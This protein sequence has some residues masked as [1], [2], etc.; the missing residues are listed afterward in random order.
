[1]E[2][3]PGEGERRAQRGYVTQYDFAASLIYEGLA[4]GKL[5]WIGVADRQAGKFDDLVLGYAN[6]IFAYQV[7]AS[8]DPSPFS[9]RTQLLGAENLLGKIVK[10]RQSISR[11]AQAASVEIIYVSDNFPRT[12]D[13]IADLKPPVSSAAYL[14]AHNAHRLSWALFD[15]KSSIYGGFVTE[16]QEAT[17]LDDLDFETLWRYLSFK[18]GV[19]SRQCGLPFPSS[20][21]QKRIKQ[22][23]ALLPRLVADQS[24]QDRWSVHEVLTKLQW[25]SPFTLRHSHSFP[26]DALYESNQETQLELSEALHGVKSGYVALVGPP[27]SGKST[28]LAAGII[29]SPRARVLRYLAFVPGKGQGLGRAESFD[30]LHDLVRQLKLQGFGKEILP[31]GEI[32]ELRAQLERLL[33]E[34]GERYQVD[35]LETIIVVDGLDHVSR[36]ER[37]QRSFLNDFPLPDSIPDGVIFLLG[38]QRLDLIDLPASVQDQASEEGRLIQ[39]SPLSPSAVARLAELAGVS[40]D[41][42]GPLLYKKTGGHPLA[43]RYVIDGLQN[44]NGPQARQK[45]LQEGPAYGG[46]VDVFYSRAWHDLE[47]NPDAQRG[48][49]YLALAEGTIS[50]VS[51]DLIIGAPATDT[52]WRAAN[53]LLRID[54]QRNWSV[55]HNSFRLFLQTKLSMRHGVPNPDVVMARYLELADIAAKAESG[56]GQQ[57]LELR[58]RVRAKQFERALP[59]ATPDRFREQ[60]FAGRSPEDIRED[61]ALS[62]LAAKA[63]KSMTAVLSLIFAGHE[64]DMR[65]EVVGDDVIDAYIALGFLDRARGLVDAEPFSMST[66]KGFDLVEILLE[67]GDI[68]NAK[69]VFNFLEPLDVL[70]GQKEIFESRTKTELEKWAEQALAFRTTDEFITSLKRMR[71]SDRGPHTEDLTAQLE[72]LKLL[73]IR[74]QLMRNPELSPHELATSLDLG[75]GHDLLINYLALKAAF[76]SGMDDLASERLEICANAAMANASGLL[77]QISHTAHQLS[78]DDIAKKLIESA[79]IPSLDLGDYH[80]EDADLRIAEKNVILASSLRARFALPAVHGKAP[81]SALLDIYQQRLENLGS[82]HGSLLAEPTTGN[83]PLTEMISLLDFLE[84]AQG[85]ERFD[86]E[87]GRLTRTMDV[88]LRPLLEAAHAHS[89][90]TFGRLASE[91]DDRLNR[92]AP[93]LSISS[94]RRAFAIEMFQYEDDAAAAIRRIAYQPGREDTPQSEFEEVAKTISAFLQVGLRSEAEKLLACVQTEGLGI[95]RPAKKDGQYILWEGFLQ[96]ANRADPVHRRDRVLFIARFFSGLAETEGRGVA[97]RAA[98]TLIREA[99]MI[100]AGTASK[101]IDIVEDFNLSTWSDIVENIALGAIRTDPTYSEMAAL[102]FGRLCIPFD[103]SVSRSTLSEILQ[104]APEPEFGRIG[105]LLAECVQTDAPLDSRI[106]ALETIVDSI[107]RRG[108]EADASGLVRWRA[109]LPPPKSGNSP[110]DPFFLARSLEDIANLLDQYRG[111]SDAYGARSAFLRVLEWVDFEAANALFIKE[112]DLNSDERVIEAMARQSWAEGKP[113]EAKL[114]L[115]SLLKIADEKGSWGGGWRSQAKLQYHRLA[116]DL[117]M[118]DASMAFEALVDDLAAGKESYEYILPDLHEILDV[119]VSTIDWESAWDVLAKHL[120]QFREFERG[121]EVIAPVST[122]ATIEGTVADLIRRGIGTTAISLVNLARAAAIEMSSVTHGRLVLQVL[123]PDLLSRGEEFAVEAAQIIWESRNSEGLK[124]FLQSLFP[125]MLDMKDIAIRSVA[126]RLCETW[127]LPSPLK[128]QELPAIYSVILPNTERYASFDAPSGVSAFSAGLFAEDAL[129]WTWILGRQLRLASRASELELANI[130]YRVAEIMRR[131][132]GESKFGPEAVKS[133]FARMR[134]LSLHATYT[135]LMSQT[136]LQAFREAVGELYAADAIDPDAIPLLEAYS[137]AYSPVIP[138]RFPVPRPQ[139]FHA[140][141]MPEIFGRQEGVWIDDVAEDLVPPTIADGIVLAAV[142]IHERGFR[143]EKWVA[144]QYYGPKVKRQED[145]LFVQLQRIP[146][147]L[148]TDRPNYS[149]S[150]PCPGFVAHILPTVAGFEV[151]PLSLCPLGAA[152]LSLLQS[153]EDV[154]T[155]TDALG[156]KSAWVLYW[157]D[158]GIAA[159][160]TDSGIHRHGFALVIENKYGNQL[161]QLLPTEYEM[162]AWRRHQKAGEDVDFKMA[163]RE[164]PSPAG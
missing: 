60:F 44:A 7:K 92:A 151:C 114:L 132:G 72:H 49:A 119:V 48:M 106:L 10:A 70:L 22:I 13:S 12:D 141:R 101:V 145:E 161:R 87:R 91:I 25:D 41:V 46:D 39:V 18:T 32:Q 157:R 116:R 154:F 58:Y 86:F 97:Q 99:A 110:E 136:A 139:N 129:T 81:K 15:W 94:F 57:W 159:R 146:G 126:E 71:V 124:P 90:E 36:E 9:I 105:D 50:P 160:E 152:A 95:S 77:L 68:A 14:R 134:R 109:E 19:E 4:S 24:D 38:T 73:A 148:V 82:I 21:D 147:L 104:L 43:V 111:K 52:V 156:A 23:A 53:H 142:L 96:K 54:R 122:E 45:W 78:R 88:V 83:F 75:S 2:I 98:S 113:D 149:F 63:N 163:R 130:R 115:G 47:N 16:V 27:G 127:D 118:E 137:G 31:G 34:V 140:A 162:L 56:D 153:P 30:F 37:P 100:D 102:I 85:A 35:G 26:V 89:D 133:Q 51:L 62:F 158:G 8:A 69:D 5:R 131:M 20:D 66:G 107:K 17:G 1:M 74:G 112:T 138:T 143:E 3:Q 135:K 121:I 61:I 164:I 6:Q 155:Y 42:D 11:S 80:Y 103:E 108:C 28:L 84:R 67:V 33:N 117:G 29:P 76:E 59:L 144:G 93:Y 123:L 64:L 79:A 125:Q 65:M 120:S 150:K 55:F 40:S 128:H